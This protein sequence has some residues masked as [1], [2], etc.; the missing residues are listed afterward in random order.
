MWKFPNLLEIV[1]LLVG[2][3]LLLNGF[4]DHEI[5]NSSYIQLIK[6]VQ[7]PINGMECQYNFVKI[8]SVCLLR[9]ARKKLLVLLTVRLFL[10]YS[11]CK[12]GR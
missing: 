3:F 7:T 1:N 6:R 9:K 12:L 4:Y 11:R 2:T 8:W 5:G 10:I